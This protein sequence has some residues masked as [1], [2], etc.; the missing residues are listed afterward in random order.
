MQTKK[1]RTS[2][3]KI[4][5]NRLSWKALADEARSQI[6]GLEEKANKLR[7]S[8]KTFEENSKAGIPFPG[9]ATRH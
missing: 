8:V 7:V 5:K 2:L 9:S 3:S 6:R 1:S 4:D